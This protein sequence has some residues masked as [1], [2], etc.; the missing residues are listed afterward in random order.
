MTNQELM[1]VFEKVYENGY[2]SG[3]KEGYHRA[4]VDNLP[5]DDDFTTGEDKNG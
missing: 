2:K 5:L 1:E 3:Y 4:T